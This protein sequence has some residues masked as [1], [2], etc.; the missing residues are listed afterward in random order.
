[1]LT[2]L[3]PGLREIRAP[4]ISGYLWLVFFFLAF[5]G[6]LPTR[7]SADPTLKPLFNLGHDLSALGIATVSG[8]AAYLV[9]SAAQELLKW[10]ATVLPGSPLYAEAGTHLSSTGRTDVGSAVRLR[11][12]AMQRSL[13]QVALS[14]GEK[15]VDGEPSPETVE[16]DLPLIRTLL[17]GEYPDLVAELDRLQAEA[18]LRITV[19]VPIVALAILFCFAVSAVWLLALVLAGGLMVQG[20]K[21]QVEVG[22]LLAKAL[23][24]GKVDAPTLQSLDASA[25]AAI[26][27]TELEED[28]ARK[29][30][31][32]G[33]GMAAFRL[34]NL[35]ASG[36][37]Y[38][39]A[40]RSLRLAIENNVIRAYAEIGFVYE[41]L[42]Q[43]DE[44]EQAYRDGKKRKDRRATER[45]ATLLRRQHREEEALQAEKPAEEPGKSAGKPPKPAEDPTEVGRI[46]DYEN[47][48]EAGDAKAAINLGLLRERKQEMSA[49]IAAFEMA[50]SLNDEDAQAW[51]SLGR[52]LRWAGRAPDAIEALERARA[53]LELDLGRDHL[54]VA[55]AVSDLGAAMSEAGDYEGALPLLENALRIQEAELGPDALEVAVTLEF[56]SNAVSGLGD[57]SRSKE[58]DERNLRLYETVLGSEDPRVAMSLRNLAVT[59][60]RTGGYMEA[61]DMLERGLRIQERQPEETGRDR[62][63]VLDTLGTVWDTVGEFGTGLELHRQALTLVE[64]DFGPQHPWIS[65]LRIARSR[66][67]LG[68]G[69]YGQA[70]EVLFGA[71]PVLEAS[72][73]SGH[74]TLVTGL[75]AYGTALRDNDRVNDAVAVVE[76][77]VVIATPSHRHLLFESRSNLAAALSR[78]GEFEKARWHLDQALD[79]GTEL[80]GEGHLYLAPVYIR[81]GVVRAES[82]EPGKSAELFQRGQAIVASAPFLHRPL[83]GIAGHRQAGALLRLGQLDT[84]EVEARGSISVL[85]N[86][87]G[88]VHPEIATALDVLASI[89]EA[90]EDPAQANAARARAGAIRGKPEDEQGAGGEP[91]AKDD[92]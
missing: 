67:L 11:I 80:F 53:L 34:G 69:R 57:E 70:L 88:K 20:Y 81:L 41:A 61:K 30:K 83:A 51:L 63:F 62:A 31:D 28:L 39:G 60:R 25:A 49:A 85:E 44:A 10:F 43:F 6:V 32:E 56:I 50:T 92:Q 4:L 18:D 3:L 58:L 14:P 7:Q 22:D 13:Y 52:A 86:V 82:N 87:F 76:H 38:E 12:Q 23:R 16:G 9:G 42:E 48:I 91:T 66:S 15:G 36:R 59:V 55:D 68:L 27:R 37:D 71:I 45:L 74:P 75:L 26:E 89:L 8:V 17:L 5:H 84:A 79:L 64:A 33:S 72:Y 77:A 19:A 2:G 78:R 24:I 40:V 54:E 65:F 21:R 90:R 47:R 1:V 46:S 29:V 35:Q 73:G